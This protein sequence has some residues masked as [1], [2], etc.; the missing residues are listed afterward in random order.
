MAEHPQRPVVNRPAV[1]QVVHSA[2]A[3]HISTNPDIANRTAG[4]GVG[5]THMVEPRREYIK[6][7]CEV[8]ML[9]L[10]HI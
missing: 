6:A 10:I 3:A 2:V 9:S 1:N 7:D 8:L 5:C 4:V